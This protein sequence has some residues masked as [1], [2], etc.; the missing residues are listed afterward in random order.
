[1]TTEIKILLENAARAAG[2]ELK[3]DTFGNS[4]NPER[5]YNY[6]NP[7][8]DSGDSR[9]LQTALKMELWWDE[10]MNRWEAR[11]SVGFRTIV[12]FD[13]NPNMAVLLVASE[14]GKQMK[15]EI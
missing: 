7:I 6:W 15:E 10:E 13:T 3:Y 5:E 2:I 8:I 12:K 4:E 14:L 9:D 1:M 11:K